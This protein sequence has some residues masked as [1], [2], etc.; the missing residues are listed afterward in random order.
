MPP[1]D[2]A[3]FKAAGLTHLTAVSGANLAIVVGATFGLLRFTPCGIRMRAATSAVVL[4]G[5]VVLARPTPS[6]LRAAVMGLLALLAIGLGRPRALLPALLAAV[7]GLLLLRPTLA[8]Q[9]GFALS[10]A[11]TLGLIVLVPG[12]VPRLKVWLPGRCARLAPVLAVPLAAQ[13]ACVPVIAAIGKGVSLAA[14]PANLLALPAVA[15]ATVLG[16]AAAVMS[17]F[18]AGPAAAVCAIAGWPCRWL[19]AVAH[20]APHLPLATL[21]APSGGWGLC[22]VAAA[23]VAVA[24]AVKRPGGRRTLIL[25]ASIL[26]IALAAGAA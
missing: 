9:P 16:L 19:I 6:V 17:L 15:A 10:V 3:A 14:I 8:A 23:V 5:F 25:A 7:T 22:L 21:G 26:M 24:A 12:W 2:V 1:T 13:A 18:A 4:I 11:A 20:L